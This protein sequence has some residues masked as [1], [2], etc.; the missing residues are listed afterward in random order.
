[1]KAVDGFTP[2]RNM[3]ELFDPLH[4]VDAAGGLS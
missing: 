2:H 1:M 3:T 4:P